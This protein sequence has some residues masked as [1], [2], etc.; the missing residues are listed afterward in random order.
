MCRADLDLHI[1]V[2]GL[3]RDSHHRHGSF[4]GLFAGLGNSFHSY[5]TIV[6]PVPGSFR[7]DPKTLSAHIRHQRPFVDHDGDTSSHKSDSL[8]QFLAARTADIAFLGMD[9]PIKRTI[10]KGRQQSSE[11]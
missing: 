9:Q 4:G 6:Q 1:N 10:A 5:G 2:R 3:D 11:E 7:L 8:C